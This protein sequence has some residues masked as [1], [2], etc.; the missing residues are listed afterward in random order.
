MVSNTLNNDMLVYDEMRMLP[1]RGDGRYLK[2]GTTYYFWYRTRNDHWYLAM[3]AQ[4]P[5]F[6]ARCETLEYDDMPV[7]HHMIKHDRSITCAHIDKLMEEC[8]RL[9]ERQLSK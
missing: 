9:F 6:N 8:V 2:Q 5:I 7:F 1:V 3:H 4:K